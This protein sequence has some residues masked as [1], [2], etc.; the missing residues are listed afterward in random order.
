MCNN[1]RVYGNP[2]QL[3]LW[4]KYNDLFSIGQGIYR[5][6]MGEQIYFHYLSISTHF[7]SFVHSLYL[8]PLSLFCL[9]SLLLYLFLSPLHSFSLLHFPYLP[10]FRRKNVGISA[11]RQHIRINTFTP[12]TRIPQCSSY[13]LQH[14]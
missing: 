10:L 6:D 3:D 13:Q 5:R 12:S 2:M 9:L 8:C 14:N 11:L 1:L 4:S 7:A